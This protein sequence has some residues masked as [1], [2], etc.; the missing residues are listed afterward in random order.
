MKYGT[1]LNRAKAEQ[2]QAMK[3]GG[4]VIRQSFVSRRFKKILS[5]RSTP[6]KIS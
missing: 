5:P 4:E 2:M 3:K 6:R 1:P